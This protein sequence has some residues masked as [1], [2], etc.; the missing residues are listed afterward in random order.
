[1]RRRGGPVI[2]IL[3][4]LLGAACGGGGGGGAV[5][6][7]GGAVRSALDDVLNAIPKNSIRTVVRGE[8]DD[9]DDVFRANSTVV[10][11]AFRL[12][13]FSTAVD[14]AVR[15]ADNQVQSKVEELF[16]RLEATTQKQIEKTLRKMICEARL[17]AQNQ[18]GDVE[19]LKPWIAQEFQ[20][21]R[22][23]LWSDDLE[24]VA[25]WLADKVNDK[26]SLYSLACMGWVRTMR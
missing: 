8:A 13:A 3:V 24:D 19:L 26:S 12:P 16:D 10:N 23:L 15:T 22:I 9:L 17:Y 14:D 5:R 21:I 25:G 18:Q 7:G 4:C 2:L 20:R 11:G 6:S 1:M